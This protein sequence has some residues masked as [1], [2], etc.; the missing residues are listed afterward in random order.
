VLVNGRVVMRGGRTTLADDVELFAK[1]RVSVDRVIK[2]LGL[3]PPG[4]W[5]RAEGA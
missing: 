3:S 2:R 1:A 4:I 5:P